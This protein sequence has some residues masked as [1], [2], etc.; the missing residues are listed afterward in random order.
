M[1]EGDVVYT[2]GKWET[3][4]KKLQNLER[5]LLKWRGDTENAALMILCY[6]FL[7]HLN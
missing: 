1:H 2:S 5:L 6:N 4:L 7:K 3:E